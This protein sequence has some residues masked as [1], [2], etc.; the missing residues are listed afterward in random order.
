[1]SESRE[2]SQNEG[3]DQSTGSGEEGGHF[4]LTDPAGFP[5]LPADD[6]EATRQKMRELFFAS[7]YY[8]AKTVLGYDKLRPEPHGELC[9]FRD[10]LERERR[11]GNFTL[12]RSM[13]Y[14]PR[15][16]YKT[17]I[18][19]VS[20]TIQLACR[21][22]N[23]RMLVLADTTDNAE[24][25][26]TEIDNHFR[27]NTLLR[28]L[29]G[30]LIPPNFN[31][32][33]WNAS[34]MN[35]TRTVQS[36]NPTIMMRGAGTGI[37]SSHFDRIKFDDLVVE[38]HI[39]SDTEM[40]KLTK[41]MGGLE[42]LLVNDVE[43]FIDGVGSRKKKGDSYEMME[44]YYGAGDSA[45]IPLGPNAEKRGGLCVYSR[46]IYK[47]ED[48]GELIFPYDATRKS[49][50]SREYVARMRKN[51]PERF[52][53]QLGNSPKGAGLTTFDVKD[54]RFYSLNERTGVIE[55]WSD[56]E[57][58]FEGNVWEMD[59]IVLW[60][61]SV[62]EKKTSSKNAI[63]VVAK[64]AHP[65]R[66]VVESHVGHFS[67]TEALDLVFEMDEKWRPQFT[68]IE[69][70]G[71]QGWVKYSIA[72]RALLKRVP[73]PPVMEWPPE[74]SPKAQWA[75]QEHIRGLQPAVRAGLWW[76]LPDQ[77]GLRDD[78]EFYPHIKWDDSLDALAQHLDYAPYMGDEETAEA[79]RRR[80]DDHLERNLLGRPERE[81]TWDEAAFL[82]SFG[83]SGYALV[84][85]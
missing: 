50:I 44:K 53:A 19:T 4:R 32:A 23:T 38:K 42:P 49:G 1:M 15:D 3:P 51:D 25:F 83:R 36:R 33:R 30:E 63:H 2:S 77:Q 43:S 17:T 79:G 9:E 67:P 56:G 80:E 28:W 11:G 74:G 21:D 58:L 75:K 16:T 6:A 73:E 27:Y 37:E 82:Q 78:F 13:T 68:S 61:P 76:L 20:E 52:W 81:K 69:K 26:G 62:A 22:P 54:L 39:H 29:F 85:H 24:L 41:W 18:L 45:P 66:F 47:E 60:D 46:S 71:F 59:R 31:T 14:M 48:G 84:L 10:W 57:L 72:E 70:R 7:L 12:N 65:F 55:A 5:S 35:L 40:D 8:A 34:E 64:G